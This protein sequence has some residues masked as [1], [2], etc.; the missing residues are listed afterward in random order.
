MS[1]EDER[2]KEGQDEVEKVDLKCEKTDPEKSDSEASATGE[3]NDAC[4]EKSTSVAEVR[5]W[6]ALPALS[7]LL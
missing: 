7:V 5:P 2:K 6:A 3:Q 1:L 4:K